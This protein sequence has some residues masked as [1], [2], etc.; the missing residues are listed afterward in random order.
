MLLLPVAPVQAATGSF[1]QSREV[2]EFHWCSNLV[3]LVRCLGPR[4]HMSEQGVRSNVLLADPLLEAAG[5][6]VR[7]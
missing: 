1:P 3:L 7:R 5:L 4:H 6:F 2:G